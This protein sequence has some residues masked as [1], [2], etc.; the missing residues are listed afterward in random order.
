MDAVIT[1]IGVFL[2]DLFAVN[3][4]GLIGAAI[5]SGAGL[6]VVTQLLKV[7]WIKVPAKNNPRLVSFALALVVGIISA[8]ASGL[9]LSSIT[10]L[11]VFTII[12]F[13][14][15]GLTYD[16]VKGLVAEAKSEDS[17]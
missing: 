5:A 16:A 6:T 7:Q 10:T 17:K 4:A 1:I 9:V 3:W 8:I 2:S 14:V 13:I 11:I 15:S 12:A